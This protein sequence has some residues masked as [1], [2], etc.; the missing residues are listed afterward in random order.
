[1]HK[2]VESCDSVVITAEDVAIDR[3][4]R[5]LSFLGSDGNVVAVEISHAAWKFDP[6]GVRDKI[7]V[8]EYELIVPYLANADKSRKQ[9][10]GYGCKVSKRRERPVGAAIEALDNSAKDNIMSERGI[11]RL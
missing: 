9:I 7:K 11:H 2:G 5:T 10:R 4:D 1:M 3:M 6:I 8:P